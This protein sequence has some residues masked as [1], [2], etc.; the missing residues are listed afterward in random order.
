MH[1]WSQ[2]AAVAATAARTRE[3]F[4][5]E[6]GAGVWANYLFALI[7]IADGLWWCVWPASYRRRSVWIVCGG[8]G[9]L[10]MIVVSGAIVFEAGPTRYVAI[11]AAGVIGWI[12]YW[13]RNGRRPSTG[14]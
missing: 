11:A 6:F 12:A 9:F 8:H 2:A 5:W 7:W 4:G 3:L 13:A 10:A 14:G 1:H